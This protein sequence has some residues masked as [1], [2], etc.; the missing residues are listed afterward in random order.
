MTRITLIHTDQTRKFQYSWT[1]FFLATAAIVL[2]LLSGCKSQRAPD[3]AAAKAATISIDPATAGSI[4]GMVSFKGAPP[5]L[6]PLDMTQD[7]A[8]PSDPQ[9]ADGV[10]VSGGRLA[11]VF[12]YIK[13]GLPQGT[14]AVPTESVALDQKGCRYVPHVLGLMTGQQLKILN[15][16]KADH[17][18]HSMSSNNPMWNESQTANSK[19]VLKSFANP[20]M[21]IPVQC[22]QHP[23]M[24]AY[25]NVMSHPYFAVTGAD[26]SFT[27]KNL[28]PGE[29]TLAA[30]HEKL[31][32]QVL[33]VKVGPKMDSDARFT[34]SAQ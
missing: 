25:I 14:F 16:D 4:S 13:E 29:Y 5:K 22:N 8:C 20:E 28:P 11:D 33:K 2:A 15:S 12:L 31:G 10:A 1:A 6:K 18:I 17:N 26:G 9:P 7:P 24:R 23:W 21:M 32:E 27:I 34:F 3:N 30:V 19:P